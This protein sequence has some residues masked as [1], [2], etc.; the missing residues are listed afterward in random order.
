[1]LNY[2][3]WFIGALVSNIG[4]WMQRTAQDWIVLTELTDHDAVA[5]GIT[6][7]LQMAP[8]VLLVPICGYISDR[9]DRRAVLTMTNTAMGLLAVL[10]GTLVITGTIQLWHIYVIAAVGGVVNAIENP[11]K[12]GFVSELVTA[13]RLTNAVSLNSA[14]FNVA[15]TAGPSVAAGLVFFVGAGWVFYI[16]AVTFIVHDHRHPGAGPF[17]ADRHAAPRSV[18]GQSRAA[19]CAT[20][21]PGPICS[22]SSSRHS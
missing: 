3:T 10:L 19:G 12:Q 13:E 16:N 1:M 15:R 11:S 2:R 17:G 4:F 14:S 21:A 5:V 18:E 6:T 20:C 22:C 8:V 7:A 9:F